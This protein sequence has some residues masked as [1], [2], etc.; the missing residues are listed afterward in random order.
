MQELLI[1]RHAIAQDRLEA[2]E[3]GISDEQRPLTKEGIAKMELAA[4]GIA[5]QQ[6][7][8]GL[9]LNSPLLRAQQT[10][11][12]LHTV[13]PAARLAEM[14]QL[15]PGYTSRA[16]IEAL[17]EFREE[18]IAIVGHEPGLSMLISSLVCDGCDGEFQLKKGGTAL[19]R[20]DGE[21]SE[22][23]GTLL[24]LATPKQLRLLGQG[25]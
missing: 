6:Q 24:W 10:A 25:H 3:Q 9:I 7:Q 2:Y 18:R 5:S 4:R 13:F 15:A 1:V 23:G 11:A 17:A 16:L 22:G 8:C 19:L 14:E 20:F 21:I 12:I